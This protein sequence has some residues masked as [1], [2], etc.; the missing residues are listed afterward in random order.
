[1]KNLILF[2]LYA[3]GVIIFTIWGAYC[4][5]NNDL[6][7]VQKDV[8]ENVQTITEAIANDL[9]YILNDATRD[10]TF[11][12]SL[13]EVETKNKKIPNNKLVEKVLEK[14]LSSY[15][16]IKNTWYMNK[17]GIIKDIFPKANKNILQENKYLKKFCEESSHIDRVT[18]KIFEISSNNNQEKILVVARSI[19]NK[20]N[21]FKG[22]LGVSLDMK[23]IQSRMQLE[24]QENTDSKRNLFFLNMNKS[25][26][27]IGPASD[28][29]Y[30]LQSNPDILNTIITELPKTMH[31]SF[32]K[33]IKI[34]NEKYFFTHEEI[35]VNNNNFYIVGIFPYSEIVDYIPSFLLYVK[36]T[37]IYIIAIISIG[38]FII[39]H[40]VKIQFILKKKIKSLDI[41]IN[42]FERDLNVK[43]IVESDYFRYLHR[44][45]KMAKTEIDTDNKSNE[46]VE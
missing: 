6:K 4:F 25:K 37:I 18:S 21:K 13:I 28:S 10:M 3:I 1:M 16:F 33:L 38:F 43:K 45:V 34:N 5:Y 42:E 8:L 27:I 7:I 40:N 29:S 36:W 15:R 17:N 11:L 44:R 14:Y 2:I 41:Y 19:I 30:N 32:G 31:G 26:V 24:L 9:E 23:Q 39:L 46:E 22:V 20:D 35:V 12:A